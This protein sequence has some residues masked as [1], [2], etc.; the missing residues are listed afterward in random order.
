MEQTSRQSRAYFAGPAYSVCHRSNSPTLIH[1]ATR[2]DFR[3][4]VYPYI[5]PNMS[6]RNKNVLIVRF[7]AIKHCPEDKKLTIFRI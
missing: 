7:K 3:E 6:L 4:F 1:T 5:I 2:L